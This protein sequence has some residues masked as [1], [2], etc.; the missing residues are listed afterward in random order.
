MA[1]QSHVMEAIPACVMETELSTPNLG[2]AMEVVA[3]PACLTD[4]MILILGMD[5]SLQIRLA[6]MVFQCF[7][8]VKIMMEM[9][10]IVSRVSTR[11]VSPMLMTVV[12]WALARIAA[13]QLRRLIVALAIVIFGLV[14]LDVVTFA[15]MQILLTTTTLLAMAIFRLCVAW[16]FLVFA[17][18]T[19]FCRNGSFLQAHQLLKIF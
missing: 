10:V 14:P 19:L 11:V 9:A 6:K 7:S 13:L 18:E 4:A 1:V 5:Y 2:R 3:I 12:S 16:G 15:K 17:A 8:I